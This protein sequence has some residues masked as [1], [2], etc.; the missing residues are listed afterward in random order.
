M[1]ES[2]DIEIEQALP[3]FV[4]SLYGSKK[5]QPNFE[6]PQA[7]SKIKRRIKELGQATFG[8]Y[9]EILHRDP[10]ELDF[11]VSIL[12]IHTTSWFR[13]SNHFVRLENL[14]KQQPKRR[15][16]IL[17]LGCS[18][19][20]EAYS[21]GLLCESLRQEELIYDYSLTGVDIDSVSTRCAQ[22]AVYP[23]GCLK[24]IPLKYQK[25]LQ[26]KDGM[27]SPSPEIT[28]RTRFVHQKIR[29]FLQKEHAPFD[30]IFC[31]NVLIYFSEQQIEEFL[32]LVKTNWG[33]HGLL[34]LGHCD[35]IDHTRAEIFP[36]G[37]AIYG[38]DPL[39][40]TSHAEEVQEH[41][42]QPKKVLIVEDDEHARE[43]LEEIVKDAGFETQAFGVPV[44]ALHWS[45]THSFDLML[46]D[47]RM[48]GM[49]GVE[50]C[51]RILRQ[52]KDTPVFMISGDPNPSLL[53][54]SEEAGI[55]EFL[56]KPIDPSHLEKLCE[57][58]IQ[59]RQSVLT[60][61]TQ[62]ERPQKVDAILIGASTGGPDAICA[63]LKD[64]PGDCPPVVVVQ[65]IEG[66]YASSFAERLANVS[67]LV[68]TEVQE[69]TQLQEG[70]LYLASG[71]YHLILEEKNNQVFVLQHFGEREHGHRPSVDVLFR[72]A[73]QCKGFKFVAMLLTG[74]GKD[75][76][77]GMIELKE[78]TSAFTLAQNAESSVVFGMPKIA[79]ESGVVDFVGSP[80]Q[81]K[82]QIRQ[83]I[84]AGKT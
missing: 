13:E 50:L 22:R 26:H 5:F 40:S 44:E 45:R 58:Y 16:R 25:F 42:Q 46:V 83:L 59:N 1:N 21:I 72:S 63:V 3:L 78:K 82:D 7:V 81:I 30:F 20:E 54:R 62:L 11:L 4:E 49:D 51:S 79:I 52:H 48:P 56:R 65:H 2:L 36:H 19:G 15:V 29:D 68:C 17:S 23:Q 84:T 61:R 55:S 47:F 38:A 32:A 76:A 60:Y 27:V 77:E 41:T 57:I 75:G 53:K 66:M 18:T 74:M 9:L 80:A 39:D 43:F 6:T 34:F 28:M 73:S 24:S 64:F 69:P 33:R 14:L 35:S 37:N 71:S 10:K 67:G 31:R 8:Q 12:T 70:T